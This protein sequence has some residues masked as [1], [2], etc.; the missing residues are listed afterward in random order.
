MMG[1]KIGFTLLYS[2]QHM[3]QSS[4]YPPTNEPT[5]ASMTTPQSRY[6]CFRLSPCTTLECLEDRCFLTWCCGK[7]WEWEWQNLAPQVLW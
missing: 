2:K 1:V 3:W 4:L 6:L 7:M 5:T